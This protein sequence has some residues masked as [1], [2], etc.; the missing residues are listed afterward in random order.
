[1]RLG[2]RGGCFTAGGEQGQERVHVFPGIAIL[3]GEIDSPKFILGLGA[4]DADLDFVGAE[5]TDPF[6]R[7]F[8]FAGPALKF[9]DGAL[10]ELLA[11]AADSGPSAGDVDGVGEVGC[12]VDHDLYGKH[13]AAAQ[14]F[15]SFEHGGDYGPSWEARK[16]TEVMRGRVFDPSISL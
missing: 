1:M 16:V 9:D 2:V 13:H 11:E 10:L 5:R 8:G 15:A 4:F 7:K 6:H 3:S 12:L 14:R